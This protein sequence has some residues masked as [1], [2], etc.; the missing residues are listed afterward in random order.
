VSQAGKYFAPGI[1]SWHT[2]FASQ[3]LEIQVFEKLSDVAE[4]VVSWVKNKNVDISDPVCV[5][6]VTL[7][8]EYIHMIGMEFHGIVHL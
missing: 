8:S 5:I 2:V 1:T 3:L 7:D 4:P 6:C